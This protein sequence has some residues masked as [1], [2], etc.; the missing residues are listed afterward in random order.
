MYVKL[1]KRDNVWVTEFLGKERHFIIDN[2]LSTWRSLGIH[3]GGAIEFKIDPRGNL[4]TVRCI[5]TGE[6]I[7]ELDIPNMHSVAGMIKATKSYVNG[8]SHV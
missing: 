6:D 7:T 1:I 2:D 4:E 5:F 8:G 3:P